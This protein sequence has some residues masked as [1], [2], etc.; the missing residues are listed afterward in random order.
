MERKRYPDEQIDFAL[1]QTE[2]VT[3]VEH[4]GRKTLAINLHSRLA[5]IL[6]LATKTKAPLDESD[7]AVMCT[8][9]VADVRFR[10][11]AL[12]SAIGLQAMV[13]TGSAV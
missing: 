9:F 5:G 10:L 1:R 13:S 3:P 12:F 11:H 4:D 8:K 2:A 7:A 6:S